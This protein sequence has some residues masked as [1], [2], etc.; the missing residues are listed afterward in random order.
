[1][2]PIIGV[3]A[4][5]PYAERVQAMTAHR[6]A[7]WDVLASSIRPGS[8][9]AHIEL[10]SAIPN[11]FVT[12]LRNQP[13]IGLICFNGRTAATL[14][15]R[16]VCKNSPAA[17]GGI[18]QVTMPSTSPAFAAMDFAEKLRRWSAVLCETLAS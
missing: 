11:D 2:E 18:D 10:R 3:G 15:E 13:D 17:F 12:L 14:F 4:D 7:V 8:M 1:M 6:L 9:D 5:C 16:L